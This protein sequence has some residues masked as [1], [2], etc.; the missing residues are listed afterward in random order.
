MLTKI[1]NPQ[2]PI[3]GFTNNGEKCANLKKIMED[4]ATSP[5]FGFD[6]SEIQLIKDERKPWEYMN[7]LMAPK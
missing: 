5:D 7:K 3:T 6:Q 2:V 1:R 4:K